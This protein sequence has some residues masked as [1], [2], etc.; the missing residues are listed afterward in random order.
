MHKSHFMSQLRVT[1]PITLDHH[2]SPVRMKI[3]QVGV[4]DPPEYEMVRLA[5]TA[6]RTVL[7]TEGK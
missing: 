6:A 1:L 2:P 7:S 3:R 4:K 5:T